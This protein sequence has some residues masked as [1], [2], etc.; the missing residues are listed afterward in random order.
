M[1]IRNKIEKKNLNG[2]NRVCRARRVRLFS[3]SSRSMGGGYLGERLEQ[4]KTASLALRI[5]MRLLHSE[6][7]RECETLERILRDEADETDTSV[8]APPPLPKV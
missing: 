1:E 3:S 6:M 4:L 5:E 8:Q 7:A 2:I